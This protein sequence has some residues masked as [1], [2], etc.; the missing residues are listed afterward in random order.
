M[1]PGCPGGGGDGALRECWRER[2]AY[3][4]LRRAPKRKIRGLRVSLMKPTPRVELKVERARATRCRMKASLNRLKQS[5]PRVRPKSWKVNSFSSRPS[6]SMMLSTRLASDDVNCTCT[7]GPDSG[8]L[9]L[10]P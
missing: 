6:K 9:V 3:L 8:V 10:R 7:V 2:C 4:K 1:P 5:T